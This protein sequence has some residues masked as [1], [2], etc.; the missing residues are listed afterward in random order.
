M[1]S[2]DAFAAIIAGLEA[3]GFSRGEIALKAGISRSTLWRMLNGVNADHYS[4]T[5][6]RI[7]R[8]ARVYGVPRAE[9]ALRR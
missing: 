1:L 8:I 7:E 6:E 3:Q 9:S 5:V 4:Q 2:P